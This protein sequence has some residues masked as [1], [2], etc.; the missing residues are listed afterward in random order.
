MDEGIY[1]KMK[2]SFV[3]MEAIGNHFV[4]LNGLRMPDMNWSS[5]AI[6]MCAHHFGIGADG[7]LVI[8]PS[9][10]ADLRM[11]MFN[12]DGSEDSC[13]NGLRCASIYAYANGLCTNNEMTIEARDG[14]RQIDIIHSQDGNIVS[15]VNMGKPS[16]R[17]ADIPS[18]MDLNEIIDYPLLVDGETYLITCVTVGSPH[19][20][21]EAPIEEFWDRVPPISS[22]IENH[23]LFPERISVDWY[24]VTGPDEIKMHTWERAVGPTLGCGTGACSA[25]V[26]ANIHGY[27]GERAKVTSP[28]GSLLIEWPNKVD[29]YMSGPARQVF[30]GDWIQTNE[31]EG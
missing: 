20:F 6:K 15:R 8:L 10:C 14:I 26:V 13:G 17:A 30:C 22:K 25:I 12:P 11:R 2:I 3:K 4:L 5:L 27:V 28:G 18:S 16:L 19:A 21:I 24:A 9:K 23:P 1:R 7:L 29:I 31:E